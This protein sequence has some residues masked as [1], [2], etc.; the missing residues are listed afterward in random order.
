MSCVSFHPL[1]TYTLCSD[2]PCF[3]LPYRCSHRHACLTS[4]FSCSNIHS[5]WCMYLGFYS[6]SILISAPPWLKVCL[7]PPL[8]RFTAS[9]QGSEAHQKHSFTSR[10]FP[11]FWLLCFLKIVLKQEPNLLAIRVNSMPCRGHNLPHVCI[12]YVNNLS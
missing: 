5:I 4:I 11:F 3:R 9:P 1:W 12:T 8:H 7:A 2:L 10:G 6:T